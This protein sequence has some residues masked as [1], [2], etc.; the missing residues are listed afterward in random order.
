MP[1]GWQVSENGEHRSGVPLEGV[2]PVGAT[3]YD[4]DGDGEAASP[5]DL[6]DFVSISVVDAAERPVPGTVE[7]SDA[8]RAFLWR[9]VEPLTP[10]GAYRLDYVFSNGPFPR[11]FEEQV[12]GGFTFDA[13]ATPLDPLAPAALVEAGL[14]EWAD[15]KTV[16][17]VTSR[18]SCPAPC[19]G[20]DGPC[21]ACWAESYTYHPKLEVEWRPDGRPHELTIVRAFAKG[22]D[23]QP[24]EVGETRF[25]RADPVMFQAR[26]ELPAGSYC[27]QLETERLVDGQISTSDWYCASPDELVPV[28]RQEPSFERVKECLEL[29]PGYDLDGPIPPRKDPKKD[30]EQDE[31]TNLQ[32]ATEAGG[33]G[34]AETRGRGSIWSLLLLVPLI[35]LRRSYGA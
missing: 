5:G 8:A 32:L 35:G 18:E 2:L 28:E 15:S 6:L 23:D 7:W 11:A 27:M 33:C 14:S 21:E 1:P 19:G 10:G 22:D 12:T 9:S 3:F 29:P 30:P 31:E 4:Y 16:C 13:R 26:F 17:C 24:F 34:C 20:W 25:E